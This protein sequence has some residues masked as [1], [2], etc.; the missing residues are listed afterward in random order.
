MAMKVTPHRANF[1]T[2]VGCYKIGGIHYIAESHFLSPD[3]PSTMK[4][5]L[6]KIITGDLVDLPAAPLSDTIA[7]EYVCS[8]AGK[9]D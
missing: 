6:E 8:A 5:R 2:K 7:A 3:A 4:T 1:T 9:E